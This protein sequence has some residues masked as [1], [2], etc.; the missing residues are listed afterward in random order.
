MQTLDELLER[1]ARCYP[2]WPAFVLGDVR[3]IFPTNMCTFGGAVADASARVLRKDGSLI[4]WLYATENCSSLF[5]GR[6]YLGARAS[7]SPAFTFGYIEAKNVAAKS[8]SPSR[9]V[10]RST[11]SFAGH[12]GRLT[13]NQERTNA[14]VFVRHTCSRS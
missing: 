7:I 12:A 1:N 13:G 6:T 4:E 9:L 8:H 11:P 3:R 14:T 10:G 2:G 5:M